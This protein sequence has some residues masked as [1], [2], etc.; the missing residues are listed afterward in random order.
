MGMIKVS[1]GAIAGLWLAAVLQGCGG[2]SGAGNDVQGAPAVEKTGVE[3]KALLAGDPVPG[4]Q[5]Y[6]FF[7]QRTGAHFY[8]ASAAERDAVIASL[9]HYAYEGRAFEAYARED[10][11]LNPVFRF[12]NS[13]TGTHLYTIDEGE[14]VAIESLPEFSF[15]GVAFYASK[16]QRGDLRPV[17]RFFQ[18]VKG[19]HFF[20]ATE[21]EKPVWLPR[22]R[23]FGW[24]ASPS[25]WRR[26]ACRPAPS[27]TVA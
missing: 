11:G 19:F 15:E 21:S 16:T 5:V 22:L 2:A 23:H 14:K 17:Y 10:A 8:T 1:F 25:S 12:F 27:R 6:R 7:N 24:K 3:A 20:T 4:R 13:R 9:P 18:T 26:R